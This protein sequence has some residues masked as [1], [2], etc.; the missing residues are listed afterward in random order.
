MKRLRYLLVL[1]VVAV[2]IVAFRI[3]NVSADKVHSPEV[4]TIAVE[5]P[6]KEPLEIES[7]IR[8]YD[9]IISTEIINS[10]TVGSALVI[11]YKD[12]VAF[13]KCYGVKKA[14]GKDSINENTIFRLAS[15]SKTITGVLAGILDEE[16]IISLDDR[17]VDYLPDFRLK[18]TESTRH[19][20]VRNLLSHTSGLIP[21]AYDNMVE[22]KVP[23]GKIMND[24]CLVDVSASPGKLYGYQNVMFS[25]YDTIAA[26]KT[27]MKFD[28][29]IHEK[30]FEPFEMKTASTGFHSFKNNPNKAFPHSGANGNFRTLRLNDRYYSTAPAAGINA[31][32][33]DMAQFLLHLTNVNNSKIDNYI[34]Q[35]VFTPQVQ[36]PLRR[37][38]LS[39][40][41]KVD[42]KQY[43]I[44]WRII[45]Y[46]G[47]KV[48]YH[49]GYVQGY[50]T[51]IAYCEEENIGIAYLTNSPNP[52]ASKTVPSF[53]NL[54][55]KFTDQKTILTENPVEESNTDSGQS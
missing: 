37:T 43:A 41:D 36:S 26:L 32:I 50:K 44:G 54:L 12:Q 53:L 20:T 39:R 18:N 46:K 34:V 15:V 5:A 40:W 14:G 38:Y 42:S 16:N 48:A 52:V 6:K 4:D 55:F 29:I 13:L 1:V 7:V 10:G 30:V 17:V 47:R 31:S 45:G 51:E 19:L 27:K 11:T 8:E 2:V 23:L 22:E 9:S 28:E 35:T 25:L 49:G 33:S 3:K 24:L 21:H